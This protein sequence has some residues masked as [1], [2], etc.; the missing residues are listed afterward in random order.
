MDSFGLGFMQENDGVVNM[1]SSD[2]IGSQSGDEIIPAA[3][4][5]VI[6]S[7]AVGVP[8]VVIGVLFL[9]FRWSIPNL[10][11][12]IAGPGGVLI[13]VVVILLWDGFLPFRRRRLVI[14]SDSFQVVELGSR[15]IAHIPF[16]NID[17]VHVADHHDKEAGARIANYYLIIT[18]RNAHDERTSGSFSTDESSRKY[19]QL[20]DSYVE[21][22]VKI[23][24]LLQ[25]RIHA[26]RQRR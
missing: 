2:Q 24:E 5:K 17:E 22:T 7:W 3:L 19:L 14:G 8:I 1:S 26:F 6:F 10:P 18:L 12:F 15:T 13:G 11:W 16:S 23:C 9:V 21:T 20:Q 25:A 4:G